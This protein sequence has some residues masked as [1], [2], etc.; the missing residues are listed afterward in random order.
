MPV[1]LFEVEVSQDEPVRYSW[2]TEQLWLEWQ[3]VAGRTTI[4]Q[5]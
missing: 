4:H 2:S 5:W 3:K 1:Q